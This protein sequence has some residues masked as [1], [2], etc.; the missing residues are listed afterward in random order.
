MLV[1]KS[2]KTSVR[3]TPTRYRAVNT[4]RN[5]GTAAPHARPQDHVVIYTGQKP[6]RL[7]QNET[8]IVLEKRAVRATCQTLR[9]ASR[10]N[11]LKIHTVEHNILVTQLG[12]IS[13]SDVVRLRGYHTS[14][15]SSKVN[16]EEEEY[17][18]EE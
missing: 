14:S 6:P 17:S 3:D 1:S 16:E 12:D 7:M 13:T 8:K 10:L 5:Q 11:F 4:Y 18:D 15:L 9:P 2:I